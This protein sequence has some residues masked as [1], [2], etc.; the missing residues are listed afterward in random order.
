MLTSFAEQ[1]AHALELGEKNRDQRQLDVFTDRGRIARDLQDHVIQRLLATG[2]RLQARCAAARSRRSSGGSS[3]RW[4]SSTRPSGR[5]VSST[6]TLPGGC[7]GLRR[8]LL[9]TVA[10][11]ADGEA[12]SP[13][14][15]IAGVAGTV[16]PPDI[17][18]H[19]IAVVREA[20]SN[21]VRHGGA[22]AVALTVEAGDDLLIEVVDDVVGI[23]LGAARSGLRNLEERARECSGELMVRLEAA[24]A[25]S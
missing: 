6:C 16:V 9:D 11:A 12:L 19:A 7:G 25:R 24:L 13:S 3:R 22:G 2:L 8:R 10:E 14:V 1:A 15:R 5:S 18:A 17:G 4:R 20:V 21:A 23:A